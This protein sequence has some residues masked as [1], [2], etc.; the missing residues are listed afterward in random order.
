MDPRARPFRSVLYIPG[1]KDRALDKARGLPVDAIIFDLEDAVAVEEKPAARTLL[2]ETLK[3]GGYGSRF[4]I[5]RVNGFDTP[6]GRD[7]VAAIAGAGA[8]AVL[9]PKVETTAQLDDLAAA[10]PD[11]PLW[12]MMET[13]KGILNA[14]ALAA[15]PR[16]EGFVMGTNDLA[17]EL[18]CR[19]RPDRLA[20]TAS[21]THCLLAARAHGIV[22]VDGVYNAFKDEAGLKAECEQGRDLGFDGKTLIHPA[23]IAI[24]NAA[25]AP[26][27]AEI[28]LARRQIA[29]FEEA[30][31][32]GQGVAVVDGRIVE[33]LHIVTARE[34]LA[35]AAA[36]AELEAV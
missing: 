21:L 17:K 7:D 16:L 33:N 6:W 23:Q 24:A 26:T 2:A 28:D 36:I 34:T 9:L 1:S 11:V 12:A 3:A 29:A 19:F 31:R 32:A 8:D 15:H 35:K 27:E 13:P 20:L 22:A 18:G 10:I 5:V 25:F 14:A 4:R 30:E